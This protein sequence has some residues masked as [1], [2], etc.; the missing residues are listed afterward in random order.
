SEV[1]GGGEVPGG[2]VVV[3]LAPGFGGDAEV[4]AG[5]HLVLAEVADGCAGVVGRQRLLAVA[6]PPANHVHVR[7]RVHLG[8]LGEHVGAEGDPVGPHDAIVAVDPQDGGHV[9]DGE[10]L[11]EQVVA[12]DQHRVRDP[13]GPLTHVVDRVVEGDG[14]H[15][16]AGAGELVVQGLPPGQVVATASPT[17]EGDQKLL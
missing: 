13:L 15:R 1:A 17:G 11:G 2:G 12:V 14:D 8:E 6:H 5:Q 3:A 10:Q 16:E 4:E 9:A 7:S